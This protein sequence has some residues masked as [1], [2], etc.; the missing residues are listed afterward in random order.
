MTERTRRAWDSLRT[1]FWLE[2][3]VHSNWTDPLVF[4]IYTVVRPLGA[5]MILVGMF[6]AVSGGERGPL[7]DYLVVGSAVWAV[8]LAGLTGVAFA[9]VQDREHWHM[10]RPIYTSPV[11][12]PAYLLGRAC[13]SIAS[14]GGGGLLATVLVGWLFLG[15]DFDPG[16]SGLALAVV[17]SALGVAAVL[18][19]GMLAVAY[20][21]ALPGEAWRIPDALSASLY[22][23]CGA[24][25]PVGVLPG[26]L[27]GV[28]AAFP[29]TWWLEALRRFL[30]GDGARLSY[31]GHSDGEV[32]GLLALTSTVAVAL[33][34][35]TFGFCERRA[36]RLGLLDRETGY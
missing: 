6:Y 25:F 11:S 22:L 33:A 30:L 21:L 7:L 24:I 12:W 1:G 20:L 16:W 18:A 14:I 27:Q 8:V 4:A 36:R 17:A 10:T 34:V 26:F 29:F 28:S 2:W 23:V 15:V 13:S 32:L 9:V 35:V 5:A 19:V 31:P 3:K